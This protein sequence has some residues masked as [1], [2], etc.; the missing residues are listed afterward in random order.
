VE[1]LLEVKGQKQESR[2]KATDR[3]GRSERLE[4]RSESAEGQRV[5][6]G[7]SEAKSQESRAKAPRPGSPEIRS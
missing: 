6:E 1:D 3:E 4:A 2:A 5:D 7:K